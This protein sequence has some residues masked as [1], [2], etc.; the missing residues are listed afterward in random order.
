MN[1]NAS[2]QRDSSI[3]HAFIARLLET[4]QDVCKCALRT[5]LIMPERRVIIIQCYLFSLITEKKS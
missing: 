3:L 1:K 2:A 5:K 4:E